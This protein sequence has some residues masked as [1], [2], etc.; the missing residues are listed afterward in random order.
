M[1]G[2][3]QV[4]LKKEDKSGILE[5]EKQRYVREEAFSWRFRFYWGLRVQGSRMWYMSG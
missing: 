1:I 5:R 4:L 2:V 3:I